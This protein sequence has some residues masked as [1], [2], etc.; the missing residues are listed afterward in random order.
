MAVAA[1]GAKS[2]GEWWAAERELIMNRV[3]EV[4]NL[5]DVGQLRESTDAGKLVR[6]VLLLAIK[7]EAEFV[8]LDSRPDGMTIRYC[9]AGVWYEMVPP[10]RHLATGI[11]KELRVLTRAAA[12]GRRWADWLRPTWWRQ[13]RTQVKAHSGNFACR[14]NTTVI[15]IWARFVAS[16][17]GERAVLSLRPA[18]ACRHRAQATLNQYLS[19]GPPA[20][21]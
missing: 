16:L 7:D 9:I 18:R 3:K 19:S 11:M 6:M 20:G 1:A 4:F 5:A 12:P 10:P 15:D 14:V 13:R 21:K 17:S 2:G 8:L